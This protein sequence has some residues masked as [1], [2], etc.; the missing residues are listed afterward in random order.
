MKVLPDS[1]Y[2]IFSDKIYLRRL[3]IDD[4]NDKYVS[5]LNNPQVNHF[6]SA[7]M[8]NI[9]LNQRKNI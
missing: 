3:S 9:L 2:K 7:D 5:W 8:L 1:K 6:S 4:V